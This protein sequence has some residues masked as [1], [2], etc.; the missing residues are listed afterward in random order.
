[1]IR[2]SFSIDFPTIPEFDVIS[3]DKTMQDG[4]SLCLVTLAENCH[5]PVSCSFQGNFCKQT[6]GAHSAPLIFF[7]VAP[8][9]T[10]FNYKHQAR[11][12]SS[13]TYLLICQ[14]VECIFI[15]DTKIYISMSNL[16]VIQNIKYTIIKADDR[17]G[18][19]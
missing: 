6:S 15:Q 5:G 11:R 2:Q 14:V 9:K 10:K 1:M 3:S 13:I 16:I 4:K 19:S 12:T 18:I 8:I 17:Q 7:V